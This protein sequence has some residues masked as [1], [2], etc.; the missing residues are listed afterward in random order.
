MSQ[1]TLL[2]L[3]HDLCVDAYINKER[4]YMCACVG[5]WGDK[6]RGTHWSKRIAVCSLTL[7]KLRD[8]PV[9]FP[10]LHDANKL[11]LMGWLNIFGKLCLLP[12]ISSV[13]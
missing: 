4:L 5:G 6:G 10:V 7:I 11:H 8:R 12:V 13:M 1:E 3:R 2:P 9:S